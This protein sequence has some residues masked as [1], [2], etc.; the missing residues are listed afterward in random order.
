M[1]WSHECTCISHIHDSGI[2]SWRPICIQ[3]N[4]NE[5]TI[6]RIGKDCTNQTRGTLRNLHHNQRICTSDK[7]ICPCKPHNFGIFV[8]PNKWMPQ[9]V[10]K[11]LK[12][13]TTNTKYC[14]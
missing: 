7:S 9:T 1:H 8:E 2:V 6:M 10:N 13:A 11:C 3:E 12:Y 4:V 14:I 5:T